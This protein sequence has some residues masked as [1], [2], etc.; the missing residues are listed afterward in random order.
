M[1]NTKRDNIFIVEGTVFEALDVYENLVDNWVEVANLVK[2]DMNFVKSILK[3]KN[4][5]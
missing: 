4:I 5:F 3:G 1:E 2:D